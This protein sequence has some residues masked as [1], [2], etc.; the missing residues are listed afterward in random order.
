MD[1]HDSYTWNLVHLV[2]GVTGRCPGRPARRGGRRGRAPAQ[3]RRAVARPGS[4]GRWPADFAVGRRGAGRGGPA[5]ARRLPRHAG[6]RDDVRR[7]GRARSAGPRRGGPDRHDGRASSAACRRHSPPCATTRSRRC[8]LPRGL[9]ATA[10]VAGSDGVVMGVRHRRPAARGRAV[11]P[12]VDPVRARRRAGRE[13]PG[14]VV[15]PDRERDPVAYFREIAAR[16]PRCFWLDG[17]GAREWSGRR[18]IDRLAGRR[19][20][21][22]DVRRRPRAR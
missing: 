4:P 19:R 1:H 22:A 3:P 13:L 15:S 9:V 20:R 6:P 10:H 2:A 8:T 7:H 16:H 5:G 12:R 18:S 21:L 11:P 17:G 14:A